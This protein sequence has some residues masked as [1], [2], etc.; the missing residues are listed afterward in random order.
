MLKARLCRGLASISTG[1]NS[2]AFLDIDDAAACG[3]DIP[4]DLVKV[5]LA[6]ANR[7]ATALQAASTDARWADAAQLA[8]ALADNAAGLGFLVLE[9]TARA[10]AAIAER[11]GN[12]HGLRNEAQLLVLEHERLQL[13][14]QYLYP[15]LVA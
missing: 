10:F 9:K 3:C 2:L 1:M 11:G 6:R 13:A 8:R 4:F 15:D 7:H 5:Y 12:A 14:L